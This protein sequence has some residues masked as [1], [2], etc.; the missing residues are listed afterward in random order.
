MTDAINPEPAAP[1]KKGCLRT[2]GCLGQIGLVLAGAAGASFGAYT[3]RVNTDVQVEQYNQSATSPNLDSD[4]EAADKVMG[5]VGD[6]VSYP[7]KARGYMTPDRY[8]AVRHMAFEVAQIDD[9]SPADD[10]QRFLLYRELGAAVRMNDEPGSGI[11]I[12]SSHFRKYV[13]D[14][15]GN[16]P[17]KF[18]KWREF[19]NISG[20]VS[21]DESRA[22]VL[23]KAYLK[24]DSKSQSGN[25]NGVVDDTEWARALKQMGYNTIEYQLMQA[26]KQSAEQS[27]KELEA[28][29]AGLETGHALTIKDVSPRVTQDQLSKYTSTY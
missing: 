10:T 28:I 15:T 25:E 18:D 3:I 29:V 4:K 14:H 21:L 27:K 13:K 7:V 9:K 20:T 5:F 26:S 1:K 22:A 12:P 16:K 11:Y 24:A 2:L 8:R 19:T 17:E 6:V 23:G